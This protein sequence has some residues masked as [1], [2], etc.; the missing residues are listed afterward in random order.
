M[1]KEPL[2]T[3]FDVETPNRRNGSIC[4]IG[5]VQ[6]AFGGEVVSRCDLLIDPEERFDDAS[7]SIHGIS[8]AMVSGAPTF[9]DAWERYL[10]GYFDGALVAAH[11]ASFDL[12]V[13]SKALDRIGIAM[14]DIEYSCTMHMARTS[15]IAVASYRLPDVCEALGVAMG[16]HHRAIDDAEACKDVF[17]RLAGSVDLGS[18]FSPYIPF[19]R[20]EARRASDKEVS[21]A[22]I[23]LYGL[24]I[25][26]S[27][28]GVVTS[29]EAS[30]LAAWRDAHSHLANDSRMSFALSAVDNALADGRVDDSERSMLFSIA[31]S[32]AEESA[33]NRRTTAMQ[34]L[35]GM[36]KGVS[37][38]GE[39]SVREAR[40]LLDWI[41]DHEEIADEPS[42]EP[43]FALIS[44]SL[45]DGVITEEEHSAMMA[46]IE[47]VVNPSSAESP[48]E[49]E[50]NRFVLSGDFLHGPKPSVAEFI[51]SK[52]G[53]VSG[54]VSK[55]CRYVV[56]GGSGSEAYAFGN[57]GTKAK[58]A[59]ELKA[60][61]ANIDIV[62][63][64]QLYGD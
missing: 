22:M 40:N 14:P 53:Q 16:V 51:E 48:V 7:M 64:C 17:W 12:A 30:S 18:E 13:L 39:I 43:V 27:L 56:I 58:K 57:Y 29:E 6:T 42:V 52:G 24:L 34:E 49:F 10:R 28:D 38:D 2:Y 46:A 63:E 41:D 19:S 50:G 23:D 1:D 59:L 62:K 35:L 36:L 44:E 61:G 4:S 47:G 31:R 60:K 37:A 11:N 8:P 54:S 20:A 15:R 33:Y 26:I 3:F 25:G 32:H 5:V 45:A 21:K 55:K 9:R